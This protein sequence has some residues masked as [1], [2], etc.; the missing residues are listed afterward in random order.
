M[1]NIADKQQVLPG[2]ENC[3]TN[4]SKLRHQDN[5]HIQKDLSFK[6]YADSSKCLD[7]F[8]LLGKNVAI[9]IH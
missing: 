8:I 3:G 2:Q 4:A 5:F 1:K 9:I 6:L 7:S